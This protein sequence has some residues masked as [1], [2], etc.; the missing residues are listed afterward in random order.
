MVHISNIWWNI[1]G[2]IQ[3]DTRHAVCSFSSLYSFFNRTFLTSIFIGSPACSCP[4]QAV[5]F[6][7]RGVVIDQHTHHAAIQ[8]LNQDVVPRDDAVFIPAAALGVSSERSPTAAPELGRCHHRQRQQSRHQFRDSHRRG[9]CI[10]AWVALSN[11][12]RPCQMKTQ[13]MRKQFSKSVLKF[14]FWS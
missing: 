4:D 12:D 14:H 10:S 3:T 8:N 2:W 7:I 1:W 5:Q 13:S 9:R 11:K 6:A